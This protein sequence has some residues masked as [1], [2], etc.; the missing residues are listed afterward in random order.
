[1]KRINVEAGFTLVEVIIALAI[2]TIIIVSFL[3]LFTAGLLGVFAAGDK[4]VAYSDA[5]ADIE[6]RIGTKEALATDDLIIVFDGETHTIQGGLVESYQNEGDR[7]S[8]LETFIPL[9]PTIILQ[10]SVKLEGYEEP[11]TIAVTG[12]NTSFQTANTIIDIYDKQGEIKMFGPIIPTITST[13]EASF[14]LPEN[15]INATGYYI[16]RMITT[17]TGEADEISRAKYVVEQPGLIAVGDG[18]FYV[19]E[20]GSYW[21]NRPASTLDTFPSFTTLNDVCFGNNRYVAVGNTGQVLV[22]TDQSNWS[23]T[24]VGT[25]NLNGVTWSGTLNKYFAIGDNGSLY[26][27]SNGANWTAIS[28][29][30]TNSL[31]GIAVTG[32]GFITIVGDNST[33]ITSN[34]GTSWNYLS[35]IAEYNLNDI[36]T[37]Y[38]AEGANN[39]FV[40]VGDNG[41]ILTSS[42]GNIWSLLELEAAVSDNLN[43]V[44]HNNNKFII[45]GDSGRIIVYD[46]LTDSWSSSTFGTANLYG[47]FGSAGKFVA[48]GN[49][50]TI[51]TSADAYS[52]ASYSG[53]ASGNFKAV[54]GK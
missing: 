46:V 41:V 26:Y 52:W 34:G 13:T 28:L 6:S 1:M 40:A 9:V 24:T 23:K 8:T 10:P 7:S 27:S 19:S 39:L 20:N 18:S 36:A 45:V 49:S 47:V 11:I 15:L 2:L 44:H 37:N 43:S 51:I 32:G 54:S 17:I 22:S 35:E 21:L 5:Q 25:V 16:V 12:L 31:N 53:A 38:D 14:T 42:D 30:T 33:I 48:V 50:N 3:S 29:D 4:G